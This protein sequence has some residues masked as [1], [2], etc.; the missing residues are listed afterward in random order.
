[1]KHE[2]VTSART[3]AF[4]MI[5]TLFSLEAPRRVLDELGAP[6][7]TFDIWFSGGL[8]DYFARSHSGAYAPLKNVLETT[9]PRAAR[10]VEWDIDRVSIPEVMASLRELSP[11]E[12][13]GPALGK[14]TGAG[15]RTIVVTNGSRDVA[16]H[17]LTRSGLREHVSVVISC[18]DLEV[19]KPHP[20]VYNEVKRSS[21]GE[22]WLVAAHAWD[23]AGAM[24]AGIRGVWLST[25]EHL[26]PGFLPPPDITSDD[27]DSAVASLLAAG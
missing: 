11:I 12:G 10:I 3:V 23:V 4:D 7:A 2:P 6:T 21:R 9:L 13:A 27:L 14:L 16:E 25:T 8:R 5:G 1:M 26:Y 22:V 15:W 24:Q 19:S 20:R 17:L 18:D